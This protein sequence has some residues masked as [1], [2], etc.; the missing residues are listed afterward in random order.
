M[1]SVERKKY[2]FGG[3]VD[4][5]SGAWYHGGMTNLHHNHEDEHFPC[6]CHRPEYAYTDTLCPMCEETAERE[7]EARR[8]GEHAE[9]S[10][11][12]DSRDAD[13]Q[14]FIDAASRMSREDWDADNDWLASAGWGEM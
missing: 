12:E 9:P 5:G 3:W 11:E 1:S 4:M 13:N 2:F 8:N 6:C 10:F 7:R 14:A